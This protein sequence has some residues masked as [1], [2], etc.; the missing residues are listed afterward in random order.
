MRRILLPFFPE[1]NYLQTKW[2]HRLAITIVSIWNVLAI[3]LIIGTS[4]T[5]GSYALNYLNATSEPLIQITNN[6]TM[7]SKNITYEDLGKITKQRFPEYND[8]Q[9]EILGKKIYQKYIENKSVEM[10]SILNENWNQMISFGMS[11]DQLLQTITGYLPFW[12]L[13]LLTFLIPTLIY[14]LILYIA[15]GDWW[16]K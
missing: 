16:Q 12:L 2:W 9:D 8:I 11:K 6:K 7:E 5:I 4:Y 15:L 14:R 3:I 1:N 10:E 13:S